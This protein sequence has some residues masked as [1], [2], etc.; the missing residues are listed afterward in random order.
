MSKKIF[1]NL[2]VKDLNKSVDFF[3]K[4]GFSFDPKFTNENATCMIVSDTIF[5]MLLVED[6]FKTFT[7]KEIADAAKT[8][9]VIVSLLME[10]KEQVDEMMD[11]ALGAG[12]II[13]SEPKDLG[14]MYQRG[15]QDMDGHLWEVFYM[16]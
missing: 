16:K 6:F 4:L 3:T 15:F 12:G 1:I 10:N 11:K 8:T 7:N 14:F 9:E 2:P 13:S 5:V